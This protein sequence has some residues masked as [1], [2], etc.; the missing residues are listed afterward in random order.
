MRKLIVIVA[1]VLAIGCWA[2]AP[3]ASLTGTVTMEIDLTDH[4]K[5][6]EV[7]LWIPYPVSDRDQTIGAIKISGDYAESGVYTD[8]EFSTPILFARWD[9]AAAS[10]KLSFAFDVDRRE[11]IR[12]DFPTKEGAWDPADYALYLKGTSLSPITGPVKVLADKITSGKT[13]VLGKT[14]AIYSWVLENMYRDPA[15]Y[16]CGQG[17]VCSLL[18]K[19]GGKCADIHSVFVAL[20]RAS[21]VPAREVFGLRLAKKGSEDISTWQHCWA[22]FFLPGYGW[23]PVDPADVRKAMLTEKLELKD[24]RVKELSYYYWGAV[25]PYRVKVSVGR[26]LTLNP[27]Q[28]GISVNYL[29]YPFAQVG[30]LTVDSMNPQTFKYR[31]TFKAK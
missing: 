13:S 10:R 9:R 31:I 21:G 3:A 23:V 11:V 8:K 26:D 18:E 7:K 22:E 20:A 25:D 17:D 12:R 6:K 28:K 30:E 19:P 5:D 27:L 14:Q 29:M 2:L 4:D 24:A 16:G 1:V 15:T